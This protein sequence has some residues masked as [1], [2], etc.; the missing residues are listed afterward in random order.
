[1]IYIY[2]MISSPLIMGQYPKEGLLKVLINDLP[3]LDGINDLL[4]YDRKLSKEE[5]KEWNL[6]RIGG[7]CDR[8]FLRKLKD[9]YE[10]EGTR[11][12]K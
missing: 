3:G 6:V 5:L 10:R 7:C 12:S 4:Y 8:E 2:A 9:S 1:M 11:K